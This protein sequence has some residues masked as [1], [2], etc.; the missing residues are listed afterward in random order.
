MPLGPEPETWAQAKGVRLRV[1]QQEGEQRALEQEL[2]AR[3]LEQ[4]RSKRMLTK[5]ATEEQSQ[6]LVQEAQENWQ[7][8]RALQCLLRWRSA[9]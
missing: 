9:G 7:L 3:H 2:S 4:L 6:E 5:R 8:E 1:Q